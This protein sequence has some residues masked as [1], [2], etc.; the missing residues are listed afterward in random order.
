MSA[1]QDTKAMHQ[2]VLL[3]AVHVAYENSK[4]QQAT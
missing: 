1:M 4:P 3:D 2:A